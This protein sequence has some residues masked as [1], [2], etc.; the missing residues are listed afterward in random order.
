VTSRDFRDRLILRARK[1]GV[2]LPASLDLLEAYFSLLAK[3]NAKINLTALPM[4]RPSDETLERLLIEPL[5]AAR[6]FP[7]HRSST[8]FDLGT[9]G[10]SPAIPLKIVRPALRLTM[11]ESKARKTAF[12]REAV[13]VLKLSDAVVEE[14]RFEE[15]SQRFPGAARF[16]TVRAVRVDA[17]LLQAANSLLALDGE[18]LLFRADSKEL[19]VP[20]YANVDTFQLGDGQKAYLSSYERMFHVEQ[21]P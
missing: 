10:G 1:L 8:W 15:I 13:R 6:R 7:D 16:V 11:I 2:G 17:F 14:G 5:A 18:F 19:R 20:G 21:T 9:G 4:D 3:W 12:L